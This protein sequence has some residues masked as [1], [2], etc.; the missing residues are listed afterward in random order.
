MQSLNGGYEDLK[1]EKVLA[2]TAFS[3][4]HY[5]LRN[6]VAFQLMQYDLIL[7]KTRD[8]LWVNTLEHDMQSSKPQ[9]CC[10]CVCE[11]FEHGP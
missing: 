4:H 8:F 7:I 9:M 6:L 11:D 10:L 1:A 2:H 5:A 3:Q